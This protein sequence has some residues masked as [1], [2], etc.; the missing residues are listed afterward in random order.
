MSAIDDFANEPEANEDDQGGFDA[1]QETIEDRPIKKKSSLPLI[2]AGVVM[3]AAF[4][5]VAYTKFI[6]ADSASVAPMPPPVAEQMQ[7]VPLAQD[8][9]QMPALAFNP[10][11]AMTPAQPAQAAVGFEAPQP[12]IGLNTPD[13]AQPQVAQPQIHAA[14]PAPIAAPTSQAVD[15]APVVPTVGVSAPAESG[16][17]V[18]IEALSTQVVDAHEKISALEGKLDTLQASID[19]L[20]TKI[21]SIEK[22]GPTPKASPAAANRDDAPANAK[23]V[24]KAV[25]VAKTAKTAKPEVAA[26]KYSVY[27]MRTDRVWVRTESGKT[28]NFGKG[29][30]LPGAGRIEGIDLEKRMVELSTGA[31]LVAN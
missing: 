10:S 30:T 20:L 17:K 7:P 5:F 24:K 12:G 19:A 22:K 27:A 4:S 21:D 11:Q 18:E 26:E 13:V 6:K 25:R 23:P 31:R 9:P 2:G 8:A 29:E 16:S 3:V 1:A 28:M 15:T 14:E